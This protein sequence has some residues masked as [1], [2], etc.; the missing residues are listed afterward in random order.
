MI[1]RKS[2]IYVTKLSYLK[3]AAW[4]YKIPRKEP[5]NVIMILC[6]SER[7]TAP[8][9]SLAKPNHHHSPLSQDGITLTLDC[10]LP[11]GIMCMIIIGRCTLCR[12]SMDLQPCFRR[13]G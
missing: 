7:K 4:Q 8:R 10:I 11:I 5:F 12:L 13:P 1:Q 6:V 3:K 9:N 2:R